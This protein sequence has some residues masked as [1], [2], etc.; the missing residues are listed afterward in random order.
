[1]SKHGSEPYGQD[2]RLRAV[3]LVCRE[4]W[5]A[6]RV[7]KVLGCSTRSVQLWVQKSAGGRRPSALKTGKAPGAKPKLDAPAQQRLLKLLAAGPEAAGFAGQLW[8]CPRIAELIRREFGVSYHVRYLPALL[9]SLGWSVQKPRRRALERNQSAID[10]WMA[11]DWP[12]IK[13]K[14]GNSERR[15]SFSM[16]PAF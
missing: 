15:S 13:K 14:P 7:A 12:R 16:K 4:N 6:S 9:K 5:R 10:G 3:R 2:V 1:M 11:K 8:T